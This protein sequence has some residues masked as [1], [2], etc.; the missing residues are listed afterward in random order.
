MVLIERGGS[1]RHRAATLGP[2]W[3]GASILPGTG[4]SFYVLILVD[5]TLQRNMIL[6]K[7]KVSFPA[8][9]ATP[10]AD[11]HIPANHA[12]KMGKM[13]NARLCPSHA[14]RQFD[15]CVQDHEQP[16]GHGYR[17]DQ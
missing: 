13:R 16:C 10:A 12:A 3:P 14:E 17:R 11:D 5:L 4:V 6:E 2:S 1:A 9:P 8:T 15:A 7:L